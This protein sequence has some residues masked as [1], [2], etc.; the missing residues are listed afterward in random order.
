M[1]LLISM[2]LSTALAGGMVTVIVTDYLQSLVLAISMFL[3]VF[4]VITKVGLT[5]IDESL[6]TNLG[7]A[8]FNPFVADKSAGYGLIWILFFVMSDVFAPLS[9]PPSVAKLSSTD[10]TDTVRK[11]VLLQFL[12]DKGALSDDSAVGNWG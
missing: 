5:G 12:F 11:M 8:A 3:I 6:K 10:N 7:Q 1:F 2:A 9:F 4:F